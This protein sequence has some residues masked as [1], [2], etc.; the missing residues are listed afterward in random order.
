ME[1]KKERGESLK[2][3]VRS[4]E[5]GKRLSNKYDCWETGL[6]LKGGGKTRDVERGQNDLNGRTSF[7]R[8]KKKSDQGG[9]SL[10]SRA[11]SGPG[12]GFRTHRRSSGT[13]T[14]NPVSISHKKER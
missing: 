6:K 1:G 8:L 7:G 5:D 10:G 14:K 4:G 2:S 12:G 3:L 9:G 11:G 13:R